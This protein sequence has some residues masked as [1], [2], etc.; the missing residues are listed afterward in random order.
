MWSCD[1][2][3]S[4]KFGTRPSIRELCCNDWHHDDPEKSGACL[5]LQLLS[6]LTGKAGYDNGLKAAAEGRTAVCAGET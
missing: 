5:D 2:Y 3:A 4:S 1:L 6:K